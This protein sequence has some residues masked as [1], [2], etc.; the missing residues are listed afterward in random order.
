MSAVFVVLGCVEGNLLNGDGKLE[1]YDIIRE[2]VCMWPVKNWS[3]NLKLN[4]FKNV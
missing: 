3:T 4:S 2:N 1:K